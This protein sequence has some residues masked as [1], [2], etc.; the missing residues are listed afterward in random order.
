MEKV[1]EKITIELELTRFIS[2]S[3]ESV[4]LE[5]KELNS[6]LKS[7][8]EEHENSL[9][10]K[11]ERMDV[12][13]DFTNL[14][15]K[16]PKEVAS[17]KYYSKFY[18]SFVGNPSMNGGVFI[19]SSYNPQH[20]NEHLYFDS[21]P[22]SGHGYQYAILS[23]M[24]CNKYYREFGYGY[25]QLGFKFVDESPEIAKEFIEYIKE[26]SLISLDTPTVGVPYGSFDRTIKEL[27]QNL[28][29]GLFW[30]CLRS[31][32]FDGAKE[33]IGYVTQERID[34]AVKG[35]IEDISNFSN[36]AYEKQYEDYVKKRIENYL[37]MLK[38]L[39]GNKQPNDDNNNIKN[40]KILS[41]S[42]INKKMNIVKG[43]K[44][45]INF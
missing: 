45:K 8:I 18:K 39:L 13:Y 11:C 34:R 12:I 14:E 25:N 22:L 30:Y 17:I 23:G 35:I 2:K 42:W 28:G 5:N 40:I 31:S 9:E 38:I 3:G 16:T 4:I 20:D 24:A 1:K 36:P 15:N 29:A 26:Y 10:R 21:E 27:D 43:K 41:D 32:Y 33:F 37:L 7:T 6:I 44:I 19:Y